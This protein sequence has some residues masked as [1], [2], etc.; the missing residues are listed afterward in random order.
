MAH[1]KQSTDGVRPPT[2]VLTRFCVAGT[3]QGMLRSL[4]QSSSLFC[5]EARKWR[6]SLRFWSSR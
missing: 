3:E 2:A 4:R 5:P 6:G 1:H